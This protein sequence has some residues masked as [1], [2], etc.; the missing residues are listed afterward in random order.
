MQ[1]MVSAYKKA[2][3]ASA[4][5]LLKEDGAVDPSGGDGVIACAEA[6]KKAVKQSSIFFMANE[7]C[8]RDALRAL[9]FA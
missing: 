2:A 1:S 9:H 5:T 4:L 7:S 8:R 6:V 3:S